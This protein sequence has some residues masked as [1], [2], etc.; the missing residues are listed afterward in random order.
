MGS[1]LT[2][3]LSI[4]LMGHAV[5]A[6]K[7][8][9][10]LRWDHQSQFAGYYAAQWQG[11]YAEAGFEVEIR[12]AIKPDGT[13][14]SATQEVGNGH[15]DFG[16]G[17]ADILTARDQ[18]IPLVILASI[19]QQSAAEFYAKEGTLQSPVDLLNLRVA[20]IQNDLIDVELQAMLRSEGI[21]P[22]QVTPYPHEP[23]ID[24]LMAGRVD[25]I[26]GYQI[27]LPYVFRQQG[28]PFTTLRPIN[29]GI[30]FYGDSLFTHTRWIERDPQAVQRFVKATLKGWAYA[31]EHPAEI[32]DKISQD[33]PR[34]DTVIHG[35]IHE[36]NRFQIESVKQLTLHPLLEVGH[37]NP[38]R[39]RRMHELMRTVG[40]I[41]QPLVIDELIF[42]SIEAEHQRKHQ[43]AQQTYAYWRIALYSVAGLI[44]LI[45]FWS[46]T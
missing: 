38:H 1:K 13:I 33:L 46:L 40:I 10:Q 20:R 43:K 23:G 16:V 12:S 7:V 8:A 32:A 3:L 5:A 31:L 41:K 44:L 34:T 19:F 26:P 37:I 42:D 22:N 4:L 6:E 25:V 21:D 36:F 17:A 29:Y 45:F 27:T 14:L 18:G 28:I 2:L 15:A 35:T 11:Y 24:H 9:L 30:D 39:W